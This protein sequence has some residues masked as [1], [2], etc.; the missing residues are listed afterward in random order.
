MA[1]G[2]IGANTDVE[3]YG[4]IGRHA[5]G[6]QLSNGYFVLHHRSSNA[7]SPKGKLRTYSVDASG[8]ISAL[9]DSWEFSS[10]NL[11]LNYDW[12]N[13]CIYQLA[14]N[15]YIL[16]WGYYQPTSPYPVYM[17]GAT[18]TIAATGAITKSWISSWSASVQGILGIFGVTKK[19]G[20]NVFAVHTIIGSSL[21]TGKLYTFT[22]NADGT[23]LANADSWA[24]ATV[25]QRPTRCLFTANGVLIYTY[26]VGA[27]TYISSCLVSDAGAITKAAVDTHTIARE[28]AY[29]CAVK[30]NVFVVFT[31]GGYADTFSV[32]ASGN[33]TAIASEQY[34]AGVTFTIPAALNMGESG[35]S[36]YYVVQ[37]ARGSYTG[38]IVTL[39]IAN[40]GTIGALIDEASVELGGIF[41]QWGAP[42]ASYT[43]FY[44]IP[45]NVSGGSGIF[46]VYA[47]S[48]PPVPGGARSRGYIHS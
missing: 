20:V 25:A 1:Y 10:N 3:A 39:D 36:Q 18:L 22:V 19:P 17:Y 48:A 5:A 6:L 11:Y 46:D 35:G 2:D 40:D 13:P 28:Y 24:Y 42:I 32:D 45:W 26:Q 21:N 37:Y 38:Y 44:V 15:K 12:G 9:I 47:I 8:I 4:D 23:S 14:A 30:D 43:D 31:N 41:Y 16:F 27:T 29:I 34:K 33:I 7:S